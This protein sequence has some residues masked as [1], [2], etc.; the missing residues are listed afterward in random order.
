VNSVP[1]LDE[2]KESWESLE[3]PL[4][5]E[6]MADGAVENVEQLLCDVDTEVGDSGLLKQHLSD[7]TGNDLVNDLLANDISMPDDIPIA[8]VS[9]SIE[10][11]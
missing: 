7:L 8:D 1:V 4:E 9:P 3:K 10:L 11:M 2:P 6:I 5:Q